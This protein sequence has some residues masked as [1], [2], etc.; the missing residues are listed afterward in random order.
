MFSTLPEIVTTIEFYSTIKTKKEHM[1]FLLMIIL[2]IRSR[3][4]PNVLSAFTDVEE[5]Q[6][7]M[8]KPIIISI[9]T[10]FIDLITQFSSKTRYR[11]REMIHHGS[12]PRKQA[13]SSGEIVPVLKKKKNT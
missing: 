8:T 12:L 2:Q 10:P 4:L 7:E 1:N 13:A 6:L 5:T 3:G 9:G 11:T